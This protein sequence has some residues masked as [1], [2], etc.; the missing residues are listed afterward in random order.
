MTP[1]PHSERAQRTERVHE[2]ASD[3]ADTA[4]RPL[5]SKSDHSG[6]NTPIG[7]PDPTADSDPYR[8]PRPGDDADTASGA[9][10]AGHDDGP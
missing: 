2:R 10:G 1:Q 7:D 3:P 9:P 6:L 8:R 5:E 4:D